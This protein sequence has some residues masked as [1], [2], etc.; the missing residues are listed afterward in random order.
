MGEPAVKSH[1][2][3]KKHPSTIQGSQTSS[4]IKQ[5]FTV[6]D[7]ATAS[8]SSKSGEELPSMQP[9]SGVQKGQMQQFVSRKDQHMAEI[10]WALKTVMSHYSL[11]S[12]QDITDVFHAMFPDSNIAKR[13]SCGATQL[14]Y[15]ITFGIAPFFKQELLMDVS[16]APCFVILFDESLN[17]DLHEK[18][19]DF[20]VRFIK[21]GKVEMRYLGSAFLGY[22]TAA[23]LKRNFDEATKDLDKRKMIQVSMDGPNVNWKLLSSIVDEWQSNDDYPELLDI[24][25]CSLHVIHGAFR[26]GMNK[27][28]WGIDLILKALHN[29]FDKSPAKQEDFS[30]TTKTDVFPLQFCGHRWLEDKKVA[31]RALEIWSNITTYI[32]EILKKPK[33]KIPASSSFV[34]VRSAV[35]DPLMPAK[36]AFFASTASISRYF[37]QMLL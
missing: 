11:N 17:P 25:S 4:S 15:L 16:Q 28:N 12:T 20:F 5:V 33:H 35:H 2:Q 31:D 27:T 18:Q 24:G 32:S 34:T 23:D 14:S 9:S 6:K 7:T 29:L 37:S 8:T 1:A 19:M 13:M 26:K 22:T 21:D 3:G 10:R 36:L 30:K